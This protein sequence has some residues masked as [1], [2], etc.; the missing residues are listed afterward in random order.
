MPIESPI[1]DIT[2]T[3]SHEADRTWPE[4]VK[5]AVHWKNEAGRLFI[6]TETISASEFFGTGSH[7]A[8]LSG[9]ALIQ[10]IERMRR[11]GPPKVSIRPKR[12]DR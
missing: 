4:S 3:R 2:R 1:S 7:G 12:Q 6:K 9:E 11:A 5:I 10:R 8:P